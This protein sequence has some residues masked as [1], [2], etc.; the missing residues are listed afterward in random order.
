MDCPAPA[1][2][3]VFL[4]SRASVAALP[5]SHL[6]ECHQ[7]LD[8][9]LPG[10]FG[11]AQDVLEADLANLNAILHPPGMVCNAGWVGCASG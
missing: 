11:Q 1:T 10:Q 3:R 2:V 7:R 6:E 5:A 4:R 9:L 8:A